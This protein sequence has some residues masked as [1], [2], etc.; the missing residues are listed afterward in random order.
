MSNKNH[1]DRHGADEDTMPHVSL[2]D[3]PCRKR[4]T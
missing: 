4:L 3:L 1:K 2:S